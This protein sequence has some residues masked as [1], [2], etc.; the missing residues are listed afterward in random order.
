MITLVVHHHVADYDAWKAVYDE[1][2]SVRIAHGA[3]ENRVYRAADDHNRVVVHNDFPTEEAA[4]AF[5]EDPSLQQAM[6]RA[7]IEGEPIISFMEYVERK[8]HTVA[9]A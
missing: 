6:Q 8:E 9:P 1:H 2:E 7:G 3:R 5:I 4:R